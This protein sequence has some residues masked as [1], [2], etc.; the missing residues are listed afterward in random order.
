MNFRF[1][2]QKLDGRQRVIALIFIVA[3]A[4]VI[5]H[6]DLDTRSQYRVNLYPI[7]VVLAVLVFEQFGL[8]AVA[9]SLGLYHLVSMEHHVESA[10]MLIN[11]LSQLF[12]NSLVGV[13]CLLAI[14]FYRSR[15][16]QEGRIANVR[17]DTVDYLIHE[18]RNPL[19]AARGLLHAGLERQGASQELFTVKD[20]LVD[21]ERVLERL[22]DSNYSDV[23]TQTTPTLTDLEPLVEVMLERF[24]RLDSRHSYELTVAGGTP[25]AICDRKLVERILENLLG[26]AMRYARNGKV[27]VI[28]EY[29]D[30]GCLLTV[31]DD[32]PG[33]REAEKESIFGH[34]QR[35]E[36]GTSGPP[37]LGVGLYLARQYAEAQLGRLIARPGERGVF[38]LW[39]PAPELE[40]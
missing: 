31:K 13:L 5:A 22:H 38:Q 2:G 23:N 18:L 16:E 21:V 35:G 34:H 27:E 33:V 32:G 40:I 28:L 15:L 29:A 30:Q 9:G 17:R 36:S 7:L 26:N 19:F 12:V 3:L 24:R 11:N 6:L 8:L 1:F 25:A 37:G 10:V 39:L 14:R 4:L 20:L